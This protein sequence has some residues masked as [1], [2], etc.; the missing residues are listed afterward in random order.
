MNNYNFIF[1]KVF[2]TIQMLNYNKN[3]INM[4]TIGFGKIPDQII[5]RLIESGIDLSSG[6][7]NL[8]IV[9]VKQSQYAIDDLAL[10]GNKNFEFIEKSQYIFDITVAYNKSA[11]LNDIELLFEKYRPMYLSR[12]PQKKLLDY[13]KKIVS[14]R[15]YTDTITITLKDICENFLRD[16]P[17]EHNNLE[18]EFNNDLRYIANTRLKNVDSGLASLFRENG[19]IEI[20]VVYEFVI[21]EKTHAT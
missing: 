18:R 11:L 6:C 8:D 19:K 2:D 15:T 12:Q 9:I 4:L 17:F 21:Y 20:P 10:F 16:K 1:D 13:H 3:P 5:Q 14:S 7:T